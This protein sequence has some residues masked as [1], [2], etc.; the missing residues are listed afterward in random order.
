MPA[1]A[2]GVLIADFFL[3]TGPEILYVLFSTAVSWVEAELL[4]THLGLQGE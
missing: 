1:K 3:L 2:E 4:V